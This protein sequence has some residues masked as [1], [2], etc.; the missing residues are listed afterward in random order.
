VIR[1]RSA[2]PYLDLSVIDARAPRFNQGVVATLALVATLTGFWPLLTLLGLQ[3][4]VGLTFGRRYCL[5]CVAYFEWVQPR[6]GEGPLED[7]R[8]PRFANVLGAVFLTAASVAHATG[9]HRVGTV[10]G[11]L[12]AGLALLA[13]T[14]GLCV[15]CEMYRLVARFRGISARRVRHIDLEEL[16]GAAGEDGVVVEFSHPLCTECRE[17]EARLSS[18]GRRVLTVDVSRRPELARKYGVSLVPQ[19]Y[20]VAANGQVRGRVTG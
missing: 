3:L 4:I 17:L 5:P 2:D 14:T 7:A 12:V 19:A 16:G 15:G 18:A 10:L 11:A 6:W 1:P 9:F 8:L 20:E 13:V